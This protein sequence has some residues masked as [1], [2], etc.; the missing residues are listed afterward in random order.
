MTELVWASEAPSVGTWHLMPRRYHDHVAVCD[1][2]MAFAE[3][4]YME[5]PPINVGQRCKTCEAFAD[6]QGRAYPGSP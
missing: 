2:A 4:R 1:A 6:A 5:E 3:T